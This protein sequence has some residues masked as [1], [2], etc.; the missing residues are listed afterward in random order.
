M[1]IPFQENQ[2]KNA[3]GAC[4]LLSFLRCS[5]LLALWY[6]QSVGILT[7]PAKVKAVE[8]DNSANEGL[9]L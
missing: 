7:M 6:H 2:S 4:A 9:Y 5:F 3:P 1:R 8:V